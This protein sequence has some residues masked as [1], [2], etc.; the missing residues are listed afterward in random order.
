MERKR[1][2]FSKMKKTNNFQR[3]DWHYSTLLQISLLSGFMEGSWVLIAASASGLLPDHMSWWFW[4]TPLYAHG[5][6]K[7][8]ATFWHYHEN[9]FNVTDPLRHAQ[10][11]CSFWWCHP[12][13][14]RPERELGVTQSSLSSGLGDPSYTVR[15]CATAS[16]C[17]GLHVAESFKLTDPNISCCTGTGCNHP[18]RDAQSRRGG[19]ARPGPAHLSLTIT[20]LVTACLWGG[21]LLW[22]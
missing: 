4:R 19:A 5:R 7:S 20:L 11:F 21:P 10:S 13:E 15:G 18:N 22:T 14:R 3:E 2:H 1:L 17:Q 8:Q 9:V 16:W 12:G 6:G